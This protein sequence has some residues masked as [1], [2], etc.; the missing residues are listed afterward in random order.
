MIP[1]NA[2]YE[3]GVVGKDDGCEQRHIDVLFASLWD[4]GT[5]EEQGLP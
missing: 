3:I 2:V 5:E 1:V 4:D